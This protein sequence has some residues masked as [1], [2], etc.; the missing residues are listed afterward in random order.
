MTPRDW[1]SPGRG[2]DEANPDREPWELE[3]QAYEDLVDDLDDPVELDDEEWTEEDERRYQARREQERRRT[4]RRRRQAASFAVVVLLVLGAG[5]TAAGV[6]QGWWPW[7]PFSGGDSTATEAEPCPT[8]TPTA[9][10]PGDVTVTVL[11]STDR[12]G[13]ATGVAAELAARGFVVQGV[14]NDPAEAA[15]PEPAHVRHGPEGLM[16]ARAVAA[17]I[18]GAV[19]VDDGRAGSAVEVSLGTAYQ[20]LATTEEA[21]ALAAPA[22]APSAPGCV[23]TPSP[24]ATPTPS[25]G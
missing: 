15:L 4:R 3:D 8:P 13:L 10:A 22:P 23:P 24:S 2:D 5:V 9:A 19:L 18:P 16:A 12:D 21:A 6:L 1:T 7:P 17:H 20:T 11:N 25:A 14:A